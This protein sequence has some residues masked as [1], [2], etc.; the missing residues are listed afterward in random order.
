M[1]ITDI[2]LNFL[3]LEKRVVVLDAPDPFWE[4]WRSEHVK[5]YDFIESTSIPKLIQLIIIAYKDKYPRRYWGGAI[6]N[7]KNYVEKIEN[8]YNILEAKNILRDDISRYL[9][10]DYVDQNDL[11]YL[12]ELILEFTEPQE[13]EAPIDVILEGKEYEKTTNIDSIVY[14]VQNSPI[15]QL[16]IAPQSFKLIANRDFFVY[17]GL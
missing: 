2:D 11:N 16:E 12:E 6:L 3:W 17:L 13:L 1:E 7:S 4:K 14:N 5:F 10:K 15:A 9:D 8:G